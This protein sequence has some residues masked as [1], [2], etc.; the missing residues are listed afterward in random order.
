MLLTAEH[1]I[2]EMEEP[3]AA[4]RIGDTLS[5]IPGYTDSTVCLHD[6]MC[7]VRNG[8][9]ETVWEIPGRSGRRCGE[10]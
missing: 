2:L 5:F 6:E 10:R 4:P 3:C 8:M 1:G 7:V 9:V